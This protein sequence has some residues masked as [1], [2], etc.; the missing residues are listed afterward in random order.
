MK[1]IMK[2]AAL[3]V[4][5]VALASSAFAVGADKHLNIYGA[6]A[7]FTFWTAFAPTYLTSTSVG[8]AATDS[9][10]DLSGKLGI[11]IGSNCSSN[12]GGR[13]IL[14]YTSKNSIEGVRAA[15]G[16]AATDGLN[17][18]TVAGERLQAAEPWVETAPGSGVFKASTA[19]QKVDVGASDVSSDSFVQASN[20]YSNGNVVI[21]TGTDLN[22]DLTDPAMGPPAGTSFVET[23]RQ[24]IIVPFSFFVNNDLSTTAVPNLTRQQVLLL[25]S[26]NIYNW[27]MFGKNYPDKQVTVCHRHAGSGT[28]ATL[29]Q[30]IMRGDR[31]LSQWANPAAYDTSAPAAKLLFHD[32][33][34]GLMG[35]VNTNGSVDTNKDTTSIAIGY[36]DSDANV[37]AVDAAG[38]ETAKYNNVHRIK[39]NG[40]GEGLTP[41][42]KTNYGYSAVKYEIANGAYEFWSAQWMYLRNVANTAADTT[43]RDLYRSLMSYAATT[44]LSTCTAASKLGCYW[45]NQKDLTHTSAPEAPYTLHKGS[46]D[47]VPSF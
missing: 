1:K 3:S 15:A 29:D 45:L 38:N 4:S 34:A 2:A 19:C 46:D 25:M 30:A 21:P 31:A 23:P 47:V 9:K 12:D 11:T 5:L 18:C 32:G 13:V 27:K 40:G 41:A 16:L 28:L 14:R 35:C 7:E 10:V 42:N 39:F 33:S 37:S 8:C 22:I 26:G 44:D 20:G 6:S 43:V 36:A 24:P 17:T